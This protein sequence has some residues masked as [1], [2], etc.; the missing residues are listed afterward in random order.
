MKFGIIVNTNEPETVWN[1]FRFGTTSLLED[2]EVKVFLLGNGV[3][4]EN[5]E[6][7]KFNIKEQM[8][9]F[10]E[11]DGKI[12]SCGSCLK[13]RQME[14]SEFCPVSTMHDMVHIVEESDNVLVFG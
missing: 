6:S 10:V 7:E 3:E 9:L 14:G 13:L 2:H 12:Y 1:A 4:S 8:Q 11:N 5:I